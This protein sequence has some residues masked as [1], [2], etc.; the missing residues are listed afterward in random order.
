MNYFNQIN[1]QITNV[2]YLSNLGKLKIF[3]LNGR[4]DNFHNKKMVEEH[5][6]DKTS[7]FLPQCFK[8]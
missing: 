7:H 5:K 8:R 4:G 1:G 2:L 6:S 3:V